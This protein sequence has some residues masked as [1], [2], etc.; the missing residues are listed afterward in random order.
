MDTNTIDTIR[1]IVHT[2]SLII[3]VL[4]LAG[5]VV[6][7]IKPTI[8]RPLFKEF[9]ER[10]YVLVVGAFICLLCGTIFTATQSTFQKYDSQNNQSNNAPTPLIKSD[11]QNIPNPP[12]EEPASND[13][14]NTSNRSSRSSPSGSSTATP[15]SS[16][17]PQPTNTQARNVA[18]TSAQAPKVN[19]PPEAEKK[20]EKVQ[21]L[22]VCL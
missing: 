14:E 18:D 9:C 4:V 2:G 5:F 16:T 11:N 17:A 19:T 21:L 15:T 10:K 6:G 1:G 7:L 13:S 8:L 12:N 20:C 22:F 3:F